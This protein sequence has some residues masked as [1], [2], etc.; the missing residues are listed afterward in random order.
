MKR[1]AINLRNVGLTTSAEVESFG[2][3]NECLIGGISPAS[4][5]QWPGIG[6]VISTVGG[7]RGAPLIV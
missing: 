2:E 4:V 1:G 7:G 6:D 3:G 5:V